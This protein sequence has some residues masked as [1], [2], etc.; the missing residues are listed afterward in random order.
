MHLS[1]KCQPNEF[2]AVDGCGLTVCK[3][4]STVLHRFRRDVYFN[5]EGDVPRWMAVFIFVFICQRSDLKLV[6]TNSHVLAVACM[7]N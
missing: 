1:C 3:R 7:P 2:L 4:L 6:A 5:D